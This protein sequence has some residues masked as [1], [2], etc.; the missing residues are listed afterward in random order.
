[1]HKSYLTDLDFDPGT[2]YLN[3]YDLPV[4]SL[5]IIQG[6]DA[7]VSDDSGDVYILQ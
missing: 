2:D 1:M 5:F 4:N 7:R 6:R 3:N